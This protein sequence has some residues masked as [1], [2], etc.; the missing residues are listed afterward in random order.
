MDIPFQE[1]KKLSYLEEVA[2]TAISLR[3][4]LDRDSEYYEK[5]VFQIR[6]PDTRIH[7]DYAAKVDLREPTYH[8]IDAILM[9]TK[10]KDVNP[11]VL[12][13]LIQ[14]I[15]PFKITYA[16]DE[17]LSRLPTHIKAKPEVY[18]GGGDVKTGKLKIKD[19]TKNYKDQ[20]LSIVR[21]YIVNVV[22]NPRHQPKIELSHPI[23]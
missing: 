11:T 7:K 13:L 20:M 15:V 23:M 14:G 12:D 19:H 21:G 8:L 2:A 1:P 22:E 9:L 10:Q 18:S 5:S 6:H 4:S 16:T 3:D 17:I